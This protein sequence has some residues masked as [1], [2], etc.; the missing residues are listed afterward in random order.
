[1]PRVCWARAVS[2]CSKE[3]SGEH[4]VSK[5]LFP[6]SVNIQGFKWCHDRPKAIGI[7][8][9]TANVLCRDH[10][11]ELS[12]LDNAALRAWEALKRIRGRCESMVAA[13][14]GGPSR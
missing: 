14:N 2:T 11:S 9:L 4:L 13:W 6:D 1:M 3:M 7:N 12:D 5:A 8:S 10:N